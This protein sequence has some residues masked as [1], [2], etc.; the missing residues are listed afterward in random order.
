MT[1]LKKQAFSPQFMRPNAI[2]G[3]LIT[4]KST[5]PRNSDLLFWAKF[6]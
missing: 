2:F 6:G 5:F 1:E 3:S 4:L